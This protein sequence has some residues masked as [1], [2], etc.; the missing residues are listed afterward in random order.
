MVHNCT[1][2]NTS[3]TSFTVRCSEG[4]NGGLHQA[5]LLEVR[6]SNS[7][8]LRANI[9][10]PVP[11]FSVTHLDSGALYQACIYAYNNKGRSEAMVVQAGTLRLPEKQLTSETGIAPRCSFAKR[12]K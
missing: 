6:E 3:T 7:Q 10:S 1:T 11:H 12:K 4:F 8:E 2:S 9:T 5:F